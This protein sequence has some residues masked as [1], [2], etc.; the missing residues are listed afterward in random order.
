VSHQTPPADHHEAIIRG[1][2]ITDVAERAGVSKATVSRYLGGRSD[3]L[4]A[5]TWKQIE[6]TIAELAYKPSQIARSLKGG[7]TRLI[8]MIVA[9]VANPYSIAVLRG[10]EDAC[11]RAGYLMVLCNSNGSGETEHQLLARLRAY[12]I[13]GLIL[14]SAG[15]EGDDEF[16][17]L[18]TD[19]PVVLLDRT[20]PSGHFDFVGLA[21]V[22]AASLATQHL[23]DRGFSDIAL[24]IEP[25]TGVSVR[26]ERAFGFR[27]AIAANAGNGTVCEVDLHQDGAMREALKNFLATPLSRRKAV[28]AA[29]GIVTLRVI[30]AVQALGL[31]LP[32]DLG[33]VGFDELE[34]SALV[35]PGITTISQPTYEIGAAAVRHLLARIEGDSGEPYRSV[36]AST[37]IERG[38]SVAADSRP[39][40]PL[41][42]ASAL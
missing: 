41:P 40:P 28:I 21:N 27:Q 30:Q 1:A 2:T 38:S 23:L 24:V 29:S 8:G 36:F 4:T 34:W 3:L 39:V 7:R 33:L 37:L 16:S 17:A 11:H 10:A 13:E 12:Q 32:A 35:P 26:T 14:N 31:N 19:L 15:I 20:R 9:D 22:A 6:T 18:P 5:A 25:T 42:P